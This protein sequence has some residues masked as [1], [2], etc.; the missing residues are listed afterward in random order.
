MAVDRYPPPS[1]AFRTR[2]LAACA[3]SR[4]FGWYTASN[5]RNGGVIEVW[6]CNRC[7]R[8]V[9]QDHFE[10]HWDEVEKKFGLERLET[11]EAA[12]RLG[13][14]FQDVWQDI[15]CRKEPIP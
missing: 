2:L 3:T 6:V 7:N 4:S 12:W 8:F 15:L 10:E 11:A 13:M 5:S 14:D 1:E 9:Y